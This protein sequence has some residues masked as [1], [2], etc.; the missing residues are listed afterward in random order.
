MGEFWINV[1][2][3]VTSLDSALDRQVR[4]ALAVPLN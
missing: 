2:P 1:G 4:S 3:K